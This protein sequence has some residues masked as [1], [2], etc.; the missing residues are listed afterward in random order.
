MIYF[1]H[2]N[3]TTDK[4]HPHAQSEYHDHPPQTHSPTNVPPT[5]HSQCTPDDTQRHAYS[6]QMLAHHATP[7]RTNLPPHPQS[8]PDQNLSAYPF[9]AEHLA[10]TSIRTRGPSPRWFRPLHIILLWPFV[11]ITDRAVMDGELQ[12]DK[13]PW[14]LVRCAVLVLCA[15]VVRNGVMAM[16]ERWW[17]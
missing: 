8:D 14:H 2:I 7:P 4:T 10:Q 9:P 11:D 13:L 3:M 1:H 6:A 17:V 16:S 12:V 15:A 5:F